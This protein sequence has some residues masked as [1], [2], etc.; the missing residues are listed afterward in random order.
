M[1]MHVFTRAYHISQGIFMFEHK[2]GL[3][4]SYKHSTTFKE[5]L[6]ALAQQHYIVGKKKQKKSHGS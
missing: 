5:F 6:L 4:C 2:K 1:A 3:E